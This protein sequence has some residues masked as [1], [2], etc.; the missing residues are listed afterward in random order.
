VTILIEDTARNTLVSW[1]SDAHS[2]Y[3]EV[4]GA[5]LN[6]FVS[7]V[8]STGYKPSAQAQ[9][10]RLRAAG[11]AVLFDPMTHVLQMPTVGDFRYYDEWSLWG[12]ARGALESAAERDDHVRRVFDVQDALEV[13]HLAPT[14]LLHTP[15]SSTSLRALEMAEY[16]RGL[17]PC[18][19]SVV[20][21]SAFWASDTLDAHIGALAQFEPEGWHLA[22]ARASAQLPVLPDAREVAG[23]A[24]TALALGDYAPVHVS[25]GDLAALPALA[26]GATSLGTGWDPRQRVL[27]YPNFAARDADAE[28]GSWFQRVTFRGL[29]GLLTQGDAALA[30]SQAAA[31]VTRLLSGGPLP[32][33]PKEAFLHHVAVLVGYASSRIGNPAIDGPALVAAYA[34]A[35]PEWAG[36]ATS[37]GLPDSSGTWIGELSSGLSRLVAEEGW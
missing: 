26:V 20:G 2:Q 35:L 9:V 5:T 23:L 19:F 3:P 15:Q 13:P 22:V 16:A 21:D 32:P 10:M 31:A 14:I 8:R 30:D 33:G 17:D 34:A 29:F 24:R 4:A 28:G 27:A 7:P 1:A 11:L 6:P 36:L 18:L 12:A 37:T 25:H